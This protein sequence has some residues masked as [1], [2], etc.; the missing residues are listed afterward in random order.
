MIE[1]IESVPEDDI[2][3][4]LRDHVVN[5]NLEVRVWPPAAKQAS[6]LKSAFSSPKMQCHD[7]NPVMLQPRGR[8]DQR[9]RPGDN[10]T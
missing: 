5:G 9:S 1:G 6:D 8:D 2:K 10:Q 7:L 4:Q 3:L